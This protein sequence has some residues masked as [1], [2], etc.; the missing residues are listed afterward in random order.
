VEAGLRDRDGQRLRA[1]LGSEGFEAEY[2][3]GRALTPDDVLALALRL[4]A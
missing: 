2:A 4:G 3:A 1:A